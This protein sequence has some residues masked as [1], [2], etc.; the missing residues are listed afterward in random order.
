MR[1][2][3]RF[4]LHA[5]A[6]VGVVIFCLFPLVCMTAASLKTEAD[7]LTSRWLFSP[8]LGNY[9]AIFF[10]TR[11]LAAVGSSLLI[12]S[13]TT[14][15]AVLI[16]APAAYALA[17]FDFRGK[18]DLWF[19][20]IS[21][22]LLSPVVLAL[23]V[24]L[25]AMEFRLLDTHLVLILVYLTFNLPIVVW[26]CTDHF[27][28]IPGELE[29]A[30]RLDGADQ[31]TIFRRIYL[32]LAAPGIAVSAIFSFIFSWNEL[33]YALVLTRRSVQTA[34]VVATSFMSGYELPWGKI[35]ATG[36]V[37]VLPVMLV[38]LVVSRHIVGGL[39]MG[40]TK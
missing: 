34:P 26:I 5:V 12:A 21:N 25:M 37:I 13:A 1:R 30:A 3:F 36:T 33:L 8:T 17:R 11:I 27:K 9:R 24:Y 4:L 7:I 10:E 15:L 16:G 20:F 18:S 40:A 23:P 6:L 19:W 31:F 28:A 2:P 32:P 14:I 29:Q 35:M 38:A 39:T 22:R